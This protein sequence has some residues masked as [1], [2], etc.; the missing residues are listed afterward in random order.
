MCSSCRLTIALSVVLSIFSVVAEAQE[1][2]ER[3]EV[4]AAIDDGN[5]SYIAAY[6]QSDAAAL[7]KVYDPDGSRLNDNGRMD[8][9]RDAIAASVGEFLSRVGPVR[10]RLETVDMWIVG[11]Q[12]Y[13]TGIWSYTFTPPGED[14][15]TLGGRYVTVWRQQTDGDWKILADLGVPG[16]TLPAEE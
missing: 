15:R 6:A 7:A 4:R 16:T 11:D 1:G 8:R 10:V 2:S 12:A 14:E 3:S 9:G 5:A 13:E